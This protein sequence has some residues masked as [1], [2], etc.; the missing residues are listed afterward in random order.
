MTFARLYL[1]VL[2]IFYLLSNWSC[3]IFWNVKSGDVSLS[4]ELFG[5]SYRHFGYIDVYQKNS[6]F[7]QGS[8]MK[9]LQYVR[10]Q[11]IG[12]LKP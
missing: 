5:Y 1:I 3:V 4:N 7:C 9:S 11:I 10:C 12:Y 2:M 8:Q 6:K